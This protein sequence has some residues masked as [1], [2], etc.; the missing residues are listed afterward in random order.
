MLVSLQQDLN[1]QHSETGQM[2]F[3]WTMHVNIAWLSAWS[4]RA[5]SNRKL[6]VSSA[7]CSVNGTRSRAGKSFNST[8][9]G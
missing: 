8:L 3:R 1:L 9:E 2:S 5:E 6:L 7:V 4:R